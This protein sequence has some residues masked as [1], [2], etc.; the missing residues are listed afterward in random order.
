ME[1]VTKIRGESGQN[2]FVRSRHS[3]P[4][5]RP[6]G[7]TL[8]EMTLA[9]LI[10]AVLIL[11]I[12]GLLSS[13][14]Q[15]DKQSRSQNNTLQQARFA[16]QQMLRAAA[17]AR[18]LL[19]PLAENPNTAWSESL[20]DVLAV[21]L[22][23]TLDRDQNGWADANNDQDYLDINNNKARDVQEPERIDEDPGADRSNDGAAGLIGIDDNGDGSVDNGFDQ[24]DDDEDGASDEDPVNGLDDDADGAIDED[25]PADAENDLKP[26]LRGVDD[27]YDGSVDEG[28]NSDNDEDNSTD[29]DWLDSVVFFLNGTTLMQRIPNLNPIDGTDY[30]EYPIAENVTQFQVSRI[31]GG[32]GIT[33]LVDISLTLSPPGAEPVTLATRIRVGKGL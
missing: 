8:L 1:H 21:T 18:H 31:I 26:G 16:M 30:G 17:N 29:E 9:I 14:L 24:F 7:Y 3:I 28:S 2:Q 6:S 10:A 11:G 20:R 19:I 23:P 22:D 13:A 15:A 27:D 32:D 25:P 5:Q 33:T 12:E 4:G